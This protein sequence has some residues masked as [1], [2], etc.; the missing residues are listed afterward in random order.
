M[1]TRP[2]DFSVSNA[3]LQAADNWWSNLSINQ[4]KAYRDKYFPAQCVH[5]LGRR[6]IHQIW[7]NENKPQ[8][9]ALIPV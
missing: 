6:W 5:G 7:E 8:P 4:M 1:D 3:D 2:F 9:Q